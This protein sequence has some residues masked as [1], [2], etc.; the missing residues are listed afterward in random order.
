ML[1]WRA[2]RNLG[3]VSQI[4]F[5]PG[6]LTRTFTNT[7]VSAITITGR[8]TTIAAAIDHLLA[9]KFWSAG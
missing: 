3:E 5:H 9:K 4:R 1:K 7:I 2:A 6:R 8:T